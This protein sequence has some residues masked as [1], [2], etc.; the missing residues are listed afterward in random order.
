MSPL[1]FIFVVLALKLPGWLLFNYI[2]VGENG[3]ILHS[4]PW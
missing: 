4:F 2:S 1:D 3:Y